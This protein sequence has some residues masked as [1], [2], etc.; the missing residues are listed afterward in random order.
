MLSSA[1]SKIPDYYNGAVF[2]TKVF[3]RYKVFRMASTHSKPT[4]EKHG[5]S[6]TVTILPALEDNFMYLITDTA[7]KEAAVVDPADADGVR[8]A[9]EQNKVQLRT[10]LTTHHHWDHAGGN[11]KMAELFPDIK[12]VSGDKRA[13]ATNHLVEDGSALHIGNTTVKCLFTPCHT[14]GHICYYVTPSGSGEPAVF[15]GDTLF[16]AGCGK[17][18]EGTGDEMY[19]NLVHKLGRLPA[20][21]KVYCGHEYSIQNLKFAA[22]VDSNN[23]HVQDKLAYAQERR[24]EGLPVPPS[25][26]AEEKQYNPF[27]R[28]NDAKAMA[29]M[30]ERKNNF[31]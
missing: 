13:E 11:K 20:E 10:V 3:F 29:V 8:Q 9:V 12:I 31:K 18:F 26:I 21:T 14:S 2:L 30:R 28:V 24:N 1:L 27:M 22:S 7:T 6:F 17:F 16:L 15:T 25:T 5:D 4:V 23:T 19:D